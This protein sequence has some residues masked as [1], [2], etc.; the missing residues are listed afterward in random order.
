MDNTT[1]RISGSGIT[2]D[3]LGNMLTD[4]LGSTYT[5]DAEN[6]L[7]KVVNSGG[8]YNYT[9]DAEGRRVKTA[10]TEFLYDLAG[11]AVTLLNATTG[12]WAYGEIYAGGR[13]FATY[14][15]ATTNFLHSD[16]T[17]T[18]RVMTSITG[19]PSQ[20]CTSLPFGDGPTCTGTEWD[21][22]HFT[23]DIHDGE[24][25]LEHT[26]FRPL[27]TTQG[28]FTA[29]DPY[30]GS[31]D[32]RNP[33][34]LNRY[35]YVLD[36]PLS[37]IDP[38]GLECVTFDNGTV[39]DDGNGS[40][41]DH[42]TESDGSPDAEVWG[43]GPVIMMAPG[44]VPFLTAPETPQPACVQPTSF[45]RIGIAMQATAAAF[46]NKTVGMG[47]GA[48]GSAGVIVGTGFTFSTQIVVSPNG[49]AAY[50]TT[51]VDPNNLPFNSAV[52]PGFGAVGGAQFSLS[53]A[54]TPEDLAGGFVDAGVSAGAGL[55]ISADGAIG[56]GT[57]GQLVW[58]ATVTPGF[59]LGGRGSALTPTT[60]IVTPIC[61]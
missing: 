25:N 46:W 37:F 1:N 11:R 5:W 34:S 32:L 2:Y 41:C 8:T 22:N 55:G 13:H 29:S 50:V 7:I 31:M 28:R 9:Y 4:G 58:Q 51:V 52:T 56:T 40:P 44:G 6:R 15:G 12:G 14:S 54:Q 36:N 30:P 23:D 42:M 3:A 49:Q 17:G 59:G 57:Q 19:A 48:S 38:L 47:L 43:T 39:G 33:Q 53:N 61:P 20:T 18:K 60:S 24:D 27:S 16:W 45:Q 21:F 35:S 10:S 26:W